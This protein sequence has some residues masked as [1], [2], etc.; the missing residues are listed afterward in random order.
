MQRF[1]FLTQPF[2]RELK[3][4]HKL[5]LAFIDDEVK[6][7]KA[8]ID[9]R[10]SAA[11][12]APAGAG[13]TFALRALRAALPPAR[14]HVTYLKLTDLSARDMC[15]QIADAVGAEPAGNYP[16]LVRSL[17]DRFRT[18]TE[19]LGLRQV[20]LLDEAHDM[21]PAVLRMLRL[22]TNFDMDSKLV[23]SIVLAGQKSLQ[24]NLTKPDMEDIHQRLIYCGELRLL[25]REE[26]KAYVEHRLSIAGASQAIFDVA[27]IDA[28]FEIT[29]G[30]MRAI[31]KLAWAAIEIADRAKRETV[32]TA[33]V[34]LARAKQWT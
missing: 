9:S 8:V 16:A 18:G 6:A 29:R 34:T 19:G 1:R 24:Q 20:L 3:V 28:I 25:T 14:Y 22:I 4:E 5:T 32:E 7:L 10:Q 26:T 17:E 13:K 15:R 12:V 2:T 27:A 33:D 31:D 21:R 23:L 30:N 11:L